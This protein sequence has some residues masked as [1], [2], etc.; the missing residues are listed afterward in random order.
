MIFIC[1]IHAR[2]WYIDYMYNHIV[3]HY[4]LWK[5]M[6]AY[7]IIIILVLLSISNVYTMYIIVIVFYSLDKTY[8]LFI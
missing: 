8:I 3:K 5:L 7:T 2:K 6:F 4:I 1:V